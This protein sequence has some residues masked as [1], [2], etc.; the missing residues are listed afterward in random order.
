MYLDIGSVRKY[1]SEI[2]TLVSNNVYRFIIYYFHLV[3]RHISQS[4]KFVLQN[5]DS[6]IYGTIYTYFE[7]YNILYLYTI[8][9]CPYYK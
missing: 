7:P 4:L 5:Y 1:N 8:F 2:G 6:N 9:M 3:I